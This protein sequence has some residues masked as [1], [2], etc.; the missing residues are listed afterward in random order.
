MTPILQ[1]AAYSALALEAGG[2]EFAVAKRDF[3][4]LSG[5][6]S[7]DMMLNRHAFAMTDRAAKTDQE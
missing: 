1:A 2:W 4:V 5:G 7:L 6:W 3:G